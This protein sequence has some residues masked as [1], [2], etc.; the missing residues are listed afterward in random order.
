[1]NSVLHDHTFLTI[2]A[3]MLPLYAGML[4]A[5]LMGFIGKMLL[6]VQVFKGFMLTVIVLVLYQLFQMLLVMLMVNTS[7]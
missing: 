3:S 2:A 4:S 5:F 1:M 7:G 6:G